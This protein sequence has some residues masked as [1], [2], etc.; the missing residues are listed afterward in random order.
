MALSYQDRILRD[1]VLPAIINTERSNSI[2]QARLKR[3]SRDI[4]GNYIESI[5]QIKS[6][7]GIGAGARGGAWPTQSAAE[8]LTAK[9]LLKYNRATIEVTG[10]DAAASNKASRDEAFASIVVMK[11]NSIKDSFAQDISRQLWGDGSGVLCKVDGNQSGVTTIKVNT[12]K[13]LKMGMIIDIDPAGIIKAGREIIGI[14]PDAST[15]TISGNPINV[16]NNDIITRSGAYNYELTGLKAMLG[17]T[18]YDDVYANISRAEYSNWRACL[19][20]MNGTALSLRAF[21]EFITKLCFKHESVPSIIFC[22]STTLNYLHYLWEKDGL[23]P[24]TRKIELGYEVPTVYTP[25]GDSVPVVV[26]ENCF[27]NAIVALDERFITLRQVSD[28]EWAPG[29]NGYWTVDSSVDKEVAH[30]RWYAELINVNPKTCGM[31]FNF[32]APY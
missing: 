32:V 24:V 5:T 11:G 19:E 26:D 16:N 9:M 23:R 29:A 2:L 12:T 31:L 3:T 22:N 17:T 25:K 13:Y 1:V 28:P 20:D 6:E 18:A 21:R 7:Q 8:F 15:L 14:D 10:P 30:L 27:D 4:K